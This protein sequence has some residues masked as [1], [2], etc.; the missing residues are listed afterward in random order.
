MKRLIFYIPF[1]LVILGSCKKQLDVKNPNEPTPEQAKT[2]SGIIFLSKGGVY[3]NGF[4]GITDDKYNIFL[5]NSYFSLGR[6]YHELMADVVGASAA[7]AIINQIGV[8]DYV[9]FDNGTKVTNSA[10]IKQV[11]R[12]NNTITSPG[13]NPFYYEWAWMYFMNNAMNLVLQ[14]LP[15]VSFSGDV[16]SKANTIAAWAHFW[17]GYLYGNIG[18]IYY[19]GIIN[20]AV[21]STNGLYVSKEATIAE[22]NRQYDLA[23]DA[24]GAI[25]SDA[26]YTLILTQLIPDFCQTGNG[27]VLTKE[28]W[29]RNISS[30]KARNLLVNKRISEMNSTDWNEVLTLANSGITDGDFVFT[31]RA[32]ETNFFFSSNS[33]S[34][35]AQT[36]GVSNTHFITER[37]I[38]EFEIGDKRLENNFELRSIPLVDQG[39]TI[40]YG[41]R[42]QMIDAGAGMPNVAVYG[43]Q[44][45][46]A[47]ELFIGA[48]YEENEL[49]KAEAKVNLNN[50]D[51]GLQNLDKV[52]SLQGSGLSATSG[53]GLNQSDAKELIRRERRV[54]LLFR[55]LSFYDA[56]RQGFL[57]DISQGGGR[58]N[59]VVMDFDGNINSNCTINYNF[60]DYWDVPDDELSLNPPTEGSAPVANPK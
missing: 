11:L 24:L 15:E 10:P 48:S 3:I 49:M 38:Q 31:G 20:D 36:V 17:K 1:L 19:A 13:Q 47:F 9:I 12:I 34:V 8:P 51:E 4:N 46:N 45:P 42:Y 44:T 22:S 41:T 28:M 26:D 29:R 6:A 40:I 18:S 5:G 60:L 52:R 16:T 55:G 39:G 25:S 50:I 7:N 43:N 23:L 53:T 2:E 27:G 57:D 32:P 54:A 14:T 33:G 21:N 56:R 59:A 58:T 37:L 35:S 30:L